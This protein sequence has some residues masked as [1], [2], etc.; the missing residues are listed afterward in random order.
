MASFFLATFKDAW[1]ALSTG[2]I[3]RGRACQEMDSYKFAQTD[4]L[5]FKH[6]F[7]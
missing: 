7:K 5:F 2:E 6:S 1:T 4:K 3:C